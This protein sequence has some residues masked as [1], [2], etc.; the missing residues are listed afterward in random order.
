MVCLVPDSG[1]ACGT[2][3]HLLTP[4]RDRARA[5]TRP[6]RTPRGVRGS[7][8]LPRMPD[9]VVLFVHDR[10]EARMQ[11]EAAL[12][13]SG[14][15]LVT[16]DDPARAERLAD[17]HH[18]RLVIADIAA[19]RWASSLVG[20]LRSPGEHL[21]ALA[22]VATFESEPQAFQSGAVAFVSLPVAPT[23]G[24]ALAA[25]VRD[26]AGLATLTEAVERAQIRGGGEQALQ[27]LTD[28]IATSRDA[29]LAWAQYHAAALLLQ[30]GK[31]QEALEDLSALTDEQP[32]FWRA[33]ERLAAIWEIA[34]DPVSAERHHA[35]ARAIR[36]DLEREAAAAVESR[37]KATQ[38][39]VIVE[40][41]PPRKDVI[42]ADDSDLVRDM[43]A[44]V[45]E[46]AGYRVRQAGTG[47]EALDLARASR[48][49][50]MILDGLMPGK[51]GFDACKEVKEDLYPRNPP[52]V[53]I[54][55]AIYT[56]QRQRSEAMSLYRVD[57]VLAKPTDKPL[58]EAEILGAI[59]R[60]LG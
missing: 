4:G 51:T 3:R 56:K 35:N 26:D 41:P 23:D 50:I 6:A 2:R 45:L 33:H 40:P 27:S 36:A 11:A 7:D 10:P 42:I 31:L 48:P 43:L 32:A 53:L 9:P 25:L 12:G 19:A 1:R 15:R 22:L 30:Q 24:R 46:R 13:G 57:E 55:S 16:A 5:T 28:L 58:D 21:P 38:P 52:K 54:F 18:P 37:A 14:A 29:V 8:K 39:A 34:G 49:D 60:H 59:R 17:E 44:D 20:R 47:K